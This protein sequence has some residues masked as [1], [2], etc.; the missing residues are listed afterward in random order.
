[1]FTAGD[2]LPHQ[3][4][5]DLWWQESVFVSWWDERARLGGVFRLG[6]EPN[7]GLANVWLGLVSEDGG[8]FRLCDSTI[9]LTEGDRV[10]GNLSA[11]HG[12]RRLC[13]TVP[14]DGRLAWSVDHPDVR[15]ELLLEDFYPMTN[16]WLLRTG[17]SLADEFAPNHW[18][19]SGRMTG[20]VQIGRR[21]HQIDGLYHRDHSWG[22]RKWD[23]LRSHRWVAGAFG[24]D[25]A[26]AMVTW[27]STDNDLFTGG[28][29]FRDGT[30]IRAEAVDPLPYLEAD[31]I[32]IRGGEAHWYLDD[33][34]RL[35]LRC[36]P[37]D[38]LLFS[39]RDVT[40]TDTICRVRH[41]DGRLGFCDFE[42]TNN[43]RD[44]R[45]QV[46]IAIGAALLDGL[47]HR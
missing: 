20:T 16:L 7:Q 29:V 11:H 5:R 45:S 2:E 26:F 30:I 28:Y 18:E 8:R 19:A 21:H 10:D 25:L 36:A 35:S 38:G 41:P 15:A 37:V 27:H 12:S 9:P 14:R 13:G 44:G 31:G 22:V 1:M 3:P 47:T 17:T 33:D 32:T 24:P 46:E 6:H 34:T 39:H 40:E 4:G 43:L 42:F 23:T